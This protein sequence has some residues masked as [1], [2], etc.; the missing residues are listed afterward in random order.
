MERA[1]ELVRASAVVALAE[2]RTGER[3]D[4]ELEAAG[5]LVVVLVPTDF[6]EVVAVDLAIVVVVAA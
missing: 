5:E 1:A 2:V 4:E 6:A 3:E